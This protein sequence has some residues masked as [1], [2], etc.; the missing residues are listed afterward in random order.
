MS[1]RRSCKVAKRVAVGALTLLDTL[2]EPHARP[3]EVVNRP[4]A[5]KHKGIRE[6]SEIFIEVQVKA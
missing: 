2:T 1:H 4:V 6:F 3:L 5:C